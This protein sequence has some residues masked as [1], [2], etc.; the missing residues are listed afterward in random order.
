MQH[1]MQKQREAGALPQAPRFRMRAIPAREQEQAGKEK[2]TARPTIR[3]PVIAH[4]KRS[5][6]TSAVTPIPLL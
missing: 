2:R 6:R 3:I 5:G 4:S 1:D